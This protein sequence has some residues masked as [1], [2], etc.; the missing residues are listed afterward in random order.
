LFGELSIP[1]LDGKEDAFRRATIAE[2]F[3][4]PGRRL[5]S[6]RKEAADKSDWPRL[7][8]ANSFEWIIADTRAFAPDDFPYLE[9]RVPVASPTAQM[10]SALA[11]QEQGKT[12]E[13]EEVLKKATEAFPF[14]R[15][16]FSTNLA[17]VHYNASRKDL[18]LSDLEPIQPLVS[19]AS[20][21][22][23]LRS[24]F[25]LGSLYRE[26]GRQDDAQRV[27]RQFLDNSQNSADREIQR[28]RQSLNS[29]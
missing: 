3:F 16:E 27:F 10:N 11:L 20:R 13:A 9:T 5:D 6:F 19:R 12:R 14:G 15:C 7:A 1:N 22:A 21:P 25:L 8:Q 23:C 28:S 4:R 17:I 2:R 24:Q 26:L 18:A 29:K